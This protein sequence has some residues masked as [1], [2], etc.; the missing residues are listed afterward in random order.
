MLRSPLVRMQSILVM[1]SYQNM[2]TLQIQFEKLES[3]LLGRRLTQ[4]KQWDPNL[5]QKKR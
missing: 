4:F 5:L 2:Q 3:R 1:D